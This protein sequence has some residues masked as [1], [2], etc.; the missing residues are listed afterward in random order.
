MNQNVKISAMNC[1]VARTTS[2]AD[3]YQQLISLYHQA[4][5]SGD[6]DIVLDFSGCTWFDANI[7]ATLGAIFTRLRSE[8]KNIK[9]GSLPEKVKQILS[10]NSF[11][12]DFGIVPEKD[13]NR[14]TM[15]YSRFEPTDEKKFPDYI[16]THFKGKGIPK[17]SDQLRAKFEE[18]VLELFNNAVFH[19]DTKHGIFVCGQFFPSKKRLDF[20]VVDMGV[21]I[22][23]NVLT[24]RALNL[25][26][27][28]AI[29]WA[30]KGNNT[31][32]TGSIP[33]GLGLKLLRE[34]I[35]LNG[36]RIKI[37]SD[38]GYW[39]TNKK[40]TTTRIF[41]A[42]FPGTLVNIEI[43]ATDKKSYWLASE[44]PPANVF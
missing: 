6:G 8:G 23:H 26:A 11:L 15:Q 1:A 32:R 13:V 30:V 29:E 41:D 12:Y 18:S 40:G 10:K 24:K 37:V 9:I 28:K 35:T 5:G 27:E 16:H 7:C 17:M 3:G 39:E 25:T 38:A 19:S 4:H 14:T 22:R 36:G 31:T 20:S 43:N 33:G 2:D 44:T 34:F 42:P 21:G